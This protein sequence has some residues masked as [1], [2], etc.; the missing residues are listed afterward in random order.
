MGMVHG[1]PTI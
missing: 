1:M